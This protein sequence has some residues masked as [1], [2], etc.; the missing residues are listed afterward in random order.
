[1]PR[2]LIFPT[3]ITL[4]RQP[5]DRGLPG[6]SLSFFTIAAPVP[7]GTDSRSDF[8]ARELP[9]LKGDGAQDLNPPV[10]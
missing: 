7:A 8:T 3:E 6:K 2:G 5:I 10:V 1:M 9:H 4:L